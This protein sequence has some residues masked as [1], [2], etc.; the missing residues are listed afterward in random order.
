MDTSL[1]LTPRTGWLPAGMRGTAARYF[2]V[3]VPTVVGARSGKSAGH[4]RLHAPPG[5][6]WALCGAIAPACAGYSRSRQAGARAAT[7]GPDARGRRGLGCTPA[8]CP[9]RRASAACFPAAAAARRT[10]PAATGS[11]GLAAAR[12]GRVPHPTRRRTPVG[13]KNPRSGVQPGNSGFLA[14]PFMPSAWRASQRRAAS[15][16]PA[17]RVPAQLLGDAALGVAVSGGRADDG[18]QAD[19]EHDGGCQRPEGP[20]AAG[21][22]DPNDSTA[23]DEPM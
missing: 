11:P 12:P 21:R 4:F 13:E 16:C 2:Q 5:K 3:A 17:R 23:G 7:A 1:V 14:S 10:G 19:A 6:A 22:G 9:V 8:G 20:G 18:S 15:I